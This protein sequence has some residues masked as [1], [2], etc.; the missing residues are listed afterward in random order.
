MSLLLIFWEPLVALGILA[1][2]GLSDLLGQSAVLL[3]NQ[4][5]PR[6]FLLCLSGGALL[7]VA[8][9][10]TW[11]LGLFLLAWLFGLQLGLAR[12]LYL[13]AYAHLPQLAGVLVFLPH[14]GA[15]LFHLIR[16]WV[17][18]DLVVAVGWTTGCSLPMAIVCALPGWALHFNLTHLGWARGPWRRL[19]GQA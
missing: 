5:S 9:A 18:F 14:F 2:A 4:V 8:S 15:Y 3:L 17:F 7:F 11:A 12:C 10:L 1:A 6:R 19:M 13:V 16:A